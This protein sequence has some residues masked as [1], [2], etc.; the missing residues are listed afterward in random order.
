MAGYISGWRVMAGPDAPPFLDGCRRNHHATPRTFSPGTFVNAPAPPLISVIVRSMGRP[1]LAV[2][3]ASIAAQDHPSI[4][5]IVVD[6]TGGGHPP[7]PS[8]AWKHGHAA[9]MVGG[10]RRLPRAPA[11]NV[12]LLAARG[13]WLC[14]LDDDDTYD[15][16][17]VSATLA[18]ASRHPGKLLVYGTT[19]VLGSDGRVRRTMGGGFN[20]ALMHH[21]PLFCWSAALIRHEVV[22]LGC[23]FDEAFVV[24]EDR[25][26]LAQIA[27]HSDFVYVPVAAFNYHAH[28]GTSGTTETRREAG[29]T[30][31]FDSLLR[32]KEAGEGAY[33]GWRSTR[34]CTRALAAYRSGDRVRARELFDALMRE[35]PDDPNGL[36][37]LAR[38]ALDEGVAEQA[39][40]LIRRAI[41]T[42]PFASEYRMT[43]AF[44]LE[45]LGRHDDAQ[46]QASLAALHP[47]LRADAN[48]LLQRLGAPTAPEA[49]PRAPVATMEPSP[50]IPASISRLDPCPCGSGKRYKQCCG[51]AGA[52]VVPSTER[53]VRE[54]GAWF[55]RGE[56][57][58]AKQSIDALV[59]TDLMD[60]ELA[61]TAAEICLAWAAYEQAFAF[62]DRSAKLAGG[63]RTDRLL[64]ECTDA[65]WFERM[66][67]SAQATALSVRDRIANRG[68]QERRPPMG[69]IHIVGDLGVI[70]GSRQHALA[71]YR[72]LAPHADVR[73][74]SP[75]PPLAGD[76][77]GLSVNVLDPPQGVFPERGTLILAGHH[78]DLGDAWQRTAFDRVILWMNRDRP[79]ELVQR[80]A[81]IEE[82]R[83]APPVEFAFGARALRERCG[84]PG[85]VEYSQVDVAR[86]T[87]SAPSRPE[88]G[89]LVIGRH[90]RD[91]AAKHHPNDP[92]LYRQ[93]IARGHRVRLSG[94]TVLR[95]CFVGDAASSAVELLA[96]GGIDARDFL[97]SLDCYVYRAHPRFFCGAVASV[98]E[99]MAMALPVVVFRDNL[100]AAELIEHGVDGFV[101]VTE[102]EALACID[103]L[104]ADPARRAAIGAAARRKAIAL[105]DAARRAIVARL[106]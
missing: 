7:L 54:A 79:A 70:G 12:G 73:L 15:P 1:E 31:R 82:G 58:R 74:W 85:A 64:Y 32:A 37:G 38:L 29:N 4:E 39:E 23:R 53:R 43:F 99:A 45:K 78:V 106:L 84:L 25:E 11:A 34:R 102:A 57:L 95:T 48:A 63:A 56:A 67:E 76:A 22:A 30:I 96:A 61:R 9:R 80:L 28:L 88:A 98:L 10:D 103:A 50:A 41:R 16:D 35:Y 21:G 2:A 101:V 42:N 3:L 6:A 92:S 18:A 93:C 55:A 105:S 87:P 40:P 49:A 71:L 81:D 90:S 65:I 75:S 33:H 20:R 97:A 86:F 14:F 68:V 27:R 52:D 47:Q 13:E 89:G 77:D 83:G 66:R 51:L 59:P 94:A 44:A 69:P 24:C 36:N 100:G 104:A 5:V 91:D 19:K 62:L 46:R 17:F 26:F 8:I 72:M 60:A